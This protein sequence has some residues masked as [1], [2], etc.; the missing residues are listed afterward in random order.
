[1]LLACYSVPCAVFPLLA[2]DSRLKFEG[3]RLCDS[4]QFIFFD[5]E[6]L[7]RNESMREGLE[8]DAMTFEM[9]DGMVDDNGYPFL[10]W[11]MDCGY[12]GGLQVEVYG[13]AK[14][15]EGTGV[16]GP[17]VLSEAEKWRIEE[18]ENSLYG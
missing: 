17:G 14:K 9:V 1:V 11:H 3:C 6:L 12:T 15:R 16:D 5:F 4:A 2:K 13:W 18:Y 8:E 10:Y 7:L